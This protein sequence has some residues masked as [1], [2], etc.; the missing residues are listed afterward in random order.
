MLKTM[1][2]CFIPN[3]VGYICLF[4]TTFGYKAGTNIPLTRHLTRFRDCIIIRAAMRHYAT[5]VSHLNILPVNTPKRTSRKTTTFL[6]RRRDPTTL[7]FHSSRADV[8]RPDRSSGV[9]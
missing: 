5:Y 6:M 1:I 2:F 4:L 8:T 7:S 9:T 3:I